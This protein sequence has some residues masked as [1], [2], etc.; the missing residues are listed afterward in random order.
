MNAWPSTT[1]VSIACKIAL[2][3]INIWILPMGKGLTDQLMMLLC[4]IFEWIYTRGGE[5]LAKHHT[6]VNY[7]QIAIIPNIKW[8]DSITFW[9]NVNWFEYQINVWILL[10]RKNV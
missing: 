1:P 8:R 2:Y 3:Q 9:T 10:M 4:S 6:C 7:V 5:W